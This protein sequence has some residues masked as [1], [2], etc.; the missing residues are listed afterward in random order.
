M[1]KFKEMTRLVA[2]SAAIVLGLVVQS[3]TRMGAVE[4]GAQMSD[5]S[6]VALSL[7][8]IQVQALHVQ[9]EVGA[10]LVVTPVEPRAVLAWSGQQARWRTRAEGWMSYLHPSFYVLDCDLPHRPLW[11]DV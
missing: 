9:C 2:L 5:L 10:Q 7:P 3:G 8:P 1:G 11:H 4:D 6:G